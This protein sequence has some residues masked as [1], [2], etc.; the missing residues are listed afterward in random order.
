MTIEVTGWRPKS[1]RPATD[2]EWKPKSARRIE[3]ETLPVQSGDSAEIPAVEEPVRKPES[4]S[5]KP[6]QPSMSD[7]A[8]MAG[9]WLDAPV[10]FQPKTIEQQVKDEFGVASQ[11]GV[12]LDEAQRILA[13]QQE[14]QRAKEAAQRAKGL[15]AEIK[16]SAESIK[17][18]ARATANDIQLQRRDP[19]MPRQ[20]PGGIASSYAK[21][22]GAPLPPVEQLRANLRKV[23]RSQES[24]AVKESAARELTHQYVN[25]HA[26]EVWDRVIQR[27]YDIRTQLA[28]AEALRKQ[29]GGKTWQRWER[30]SASLASGAMHLAGE[31]QRVVSAGKYGDTADE[32]ARMYYDLMNS[33]AFQPVVDN[34][35]DKYV[36]GT[37]E[38]GP[39]M[40]ATLAPAM[41]TGGAATPSLVAGFLV[42]YGIEGNLAYQAA[43]DRGEDERIARARG[44]VVG[45]VNGMI[46]VGGGSGAKYYK[47]RVIANAMTRIQKVSH[48][49][50]RTVRNALKEGLAEELPQEVVGMVLGG[51]VPR[52]E[53]GS[54]DWDAVTNRVWD[55]ATIG[56]ISGGIMDVTVTATTATQKM[57]V[58]SLTRKREPQA[59]APD[60]GW[61][62]YTLED[63]DQARLL[64]DELHEAA[65]EQKLGNVQ[66][67]RQGN[68]VR[69]RVVTQEQL[70]SER[71]A[72]TKQADGQGW[73]VFPMGDESL[74]EELANQLMTA[75]QKTPEKP[76]EIV[77]EGNVVK[78]RKLEGEALVEA[79]ERRLYDDLLAKAEEGDEDAWDQL[80]ALNERQNL[81][82]Y[83][84]LLDRAIA[85]DMEAVDAIRNGKYRNVGLSKAEQ[86][87]RAERQP[88]TT[89][90]AG[91]GQA[92]T[93]PVATRQAAPE[94]VKAEAV[95]AGTEE[96]VTV[97][98]ESR[99]SQK[100]PFT[101]TVYRGA[102][103]AENS[104]AVKWYTS[105]RSEAEGYA[106]AAGNRVG[107]ESGVEERTIQLQNAYIT[108]SSPEA[109]NVSEAK[110]KDLVAQGYDGLV[111]QSPARPAIGKIPARPAKTWV[112]PFDVP[113]TLSQLEKG[114]EHA[115]QGQEKGQTQVAPTNIGQSQTSDVGTMAADTTAATALPE[116]KPYKSMSRDEF[117]AAHRVQFRVEK[118]KRTLFVL[119]SDGV[120]TWTVKDQKNGKLTK[121][122]DEIL[123][124][125]W[126]K[127]VA[128]SPSETTTEGSDKEPWRMTRDQYVTSST[129]EGEYAESYREM[130]AKELAR[131]KVPHEDEWERQVERHIASGGT[132]TEEVADSIYES[133]GEARAWQILRPAIA[134]GAME[135]VP[136]SARDYR[137]TYR[138]F[139]GKL[140]ADGVRPRN[141]KELHKGIVARGLSEGK[142]TPADAVQ[143]HKPDYPDIETWK[144]YKEAIATDIATK[145]SQV[146]NEKSEES[147]TE[148]IRQRR[149]GE[150]RAKATE[151]TDKEKAFLSQSSDIYQKYGFTAKDA[152]KQGIIVP[153]KILSR[154]GKERTEGYRA[155]NAPDRSDVDP[156]TATKAVEDY[157]RRYADDEAKRLQSQ[158]PEDKAVE[159][160]WKQLSDTEKR[161]ARQDPRLFG[162]ENWTAGQ[163]ALRLFGDK[164]PTDVLEQNRGADWADAVLAKAEIPTQEKSDVGTSATVE[165]AKPAPISTEPITREEK[166]ILKEMGFGISDILKM[167]PVKAREMIRL[168]NNPKFRP[169]F[170]RIRKTDPAQKQI[171]DAMKAFRAMMGEEE[172]E[173]AKAAPAPT[174]PVKPGDESGALAKLKAALKNAKKAVGK[175]R[176]EQRDTVGRKTG[177]AWAQY[178]YWLSKG[179]PYREA[180]RR[181]TAALKGENAEYGGAYESVRDQVGDAIP[182]LD[183]RMQAVIEK[184]YY[185]GETLPDAMD[186][187]LD[188]HYLTRGEAR[189][190]AKYFPELADAIYTR[191]PLFDKLW[192]TLMVIANVP[193]T[194]LSGFLDM[195]G[196]GRQGRALGQKHPIEYAKFVRDYWKA[197]ASDKFAHDLQQQIEDDPYYDEA[198]HYLL[199][200]QDWGDTH[201]EAEERA[202][203]Y[204][205]SPMITDLI[206]KIPGIGDYA[207]FPFEA[208]ERSFVTALNAFRLSVYSNI[209]SAA[210]ASGKPLTGTEKAR[211]TQAINDLSGRSSL[212]GAGAA[213]QLS[214]R[215]QALRRLAPFLNAVFFSPRFIAS[216]VGVPYRI[217][218]GGAHSLVSG[219]VT[220]EFSEVA[221]ASASMAATNF[222]IM[223]LAKM[224]A[225]YWGDDDDVEADWDLRSSD[226]GKV[227]VGN[228]RFDLWAGFLQPAQFLYRMATGQRKSESGRVYEVDRLKLIGSE[229]RK[230]TSPVISLIYDT[231]KGYNFKGEAMPQHMEMLRKM[232]DG[233]LTEEEFYEWANTTGREAWERLGPLIVQDASDA[234]EQCAYPWGVAGT[235]ASFVGVGVQTYD[236]SPQQK[237]MDSKDELALRRFGT[238]WD[239]LSPSRQKAIRRDNPEMKEAEI[240]AKAER[241]PMESLDL[242]G[243][244]RTA[245][246]MRQSLSDSVRKALGDRA[247]SVGVGRVIDSD[248]YLNEDRYEAYQEETVKRIETYVSRR[249]QTP[250]YTR[251]TTVGQ[252]KML[253][254][255]VDRAR[256]EAR[257]VITKRMEQGSL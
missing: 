102:A 189:M 182:V 92:P 43:L 254:K 4:D 75:A 217:L 206:K 183:E 129:T 126:D 74:A 31:I 6:N 90:A 157:L 155:R 103:Q 232:A 239:E 121:P 194:T 34:W 154:Y 35:F 127:F 243:Q 32:Q 86:R 60:G 12:S 251:A 10:D 246:K 235:V 118:G 150:I 233:T 149:I 247:V 81:P 33:P 128:T 21:P 30:G 64:E 41:L 236:S 97:V 125:I 66:I 36:G 152:E 178:R 84:E 50:G 58:E 82:T 151:K 214:S 193:R 5:L 29:V 13:A 7:V 223:M 79:K 213:K 145:Q 9:R 238:L 146:A 186:K 42:S 195:S 176:Q 122:A 244:N 132:V 216:R 228:Q 207:A 208:A 234:F 11:F 198:K 141:T 201:I 173:Q 133:L 139:L 96:A 89:P 219:R 94:P 39:F 19:F 215:G 196:I 181:S 65:K 225:M 104:P 174:E 156:M 120:A 54:I 257:H 63:E 87:Q 200:L 8:G 250:S 27:P 101:A 164:L 95:A 78:M 237:V 220:P 24:D 241:K 71:E 166:N 17:G 227:R 22:I 51:D 202:E 61:D 85:G 38:S 55:A 210:E 107:G 113:A 46:E 144:E 28:T 142:L 137:L 253:K 76:I 119:S 15:V 170:L 116:K 242:T 72:Q 100:M 131:A 117:I 161:K 209:V 255:D 148:Q 70:Q 93:S 77:R 59:A 88:E 184:Q 56:T 248:F 205:A 1:A 20:L 180:W 158:T 171:D 224:A 203:G 226:G 245:K 240:K 111:Y 62:T 47:D 123:G 69:A 140:N 25:E 18:Q 187:L 175:I 256:E 49:T 230:K 105:L 252:Q 130:D 167:D 40:A 57:A 26:S 177:S 68:T 159:Y 163:A 192:D 188:G 91:E 190:L 73:Q 222:G 23:Y 162:E 211:L 114:T 169:G 138:Q 14:R 37:V 199:Q 2:A 229:I 221:L 80:V 204:V 172:V 109:I 67:E 108:T 110:I 112:V 99:I 45:V 124:A 83:E 16:T 160:L 185:L 231:F 134:S 52:K 179:V 249:I 191:V 136:P 48:F 168:R 153:N 147:Q 165:A 135:Y 106:N 53:D 218:A 3:P 143:I 197:F 115:V 44:V 212:T 98:R